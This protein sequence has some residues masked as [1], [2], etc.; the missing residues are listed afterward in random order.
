MRCASALVVA[1]ALVLGIAQPVPARSSWLGR[2]A[3]KYAGLESL[4]ARYER[5]TR[6]M[7]SPTKGMGELK[8]S[9]KLV[10][11]RELKLRMDQISPTREIVISNGEIVWW[12]RPEKSEVQIYALQHFTEGLKSLVGALGALEKLKQDYEVQELSPGSTHIKLV[13]IPRHPRLE[14]AKLTCWFSA[15][16]LVIEGIRITTMLGESTTY[17]LQRVQLNPPIPPGTFTYSPPAG[18]HII[19]NRPITEPRM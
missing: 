11:A 17:R 14:M 16:S 13:L 6:L 15:D 12:V 4:S 7:P 5:I 8:A 19:D 1:F 9:G 3:Q 18:Y 2:I 10:W